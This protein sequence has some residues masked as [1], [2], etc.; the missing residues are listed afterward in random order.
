VVR[1]EVEVVVEVVVALPHRHRLLDG[2]HLT[3]MGLEKK[4]A[5]VSLLPPEE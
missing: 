3:T 2:H 1:Q 5:L 4:D